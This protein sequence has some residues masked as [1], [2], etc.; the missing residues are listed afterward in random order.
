[1]GCQQVGYWAP[2][3]C[4]P[5]RPWSQRH[6]VYRERLA[7]IWGASESQVSDK[8]PGNR[9]PLVLRLDPEEGPQC[10]S[11]EKLLDFFFQKKKKAWRLVCIYKTT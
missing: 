4:R 10:F 7:L 5:R 3:E 8:G 1:M 6:S 11:A 9:L 2:G